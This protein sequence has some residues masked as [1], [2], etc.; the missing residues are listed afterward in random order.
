MKS[1]LLNIGATELSEQARQ[2]ELQG[3][4][5]EYSYID[6]NLKPFQ[7]KYR[8]LI[9]DIK[10]VISHYQMLDSTTDDTLMDERISIQIFKNISINIDNFDFAKVFEILEETKKYHF[11]EKDSELLNKIEELMNDLSVDEIK[12]LLDVKIRED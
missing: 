1:T 3:K 4:A 2:Q 6:E 8:E 7:D 12:E 10:L 11:S 5:R 9:E